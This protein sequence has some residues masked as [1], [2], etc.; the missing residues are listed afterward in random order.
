MGA[1]RGLDCEVFRNSGSYVS[2]TWAAVDAVRS[3]SY[4]I[5]SSEA[6]TNRRG[7]G[8]WQTSKQLLKDATLNVTFVK[9][10]DD[11]DFDALL[12][13]FEAGT[14]VELVAYDGGNASGSHGLDAVWE[15]QSWNETQDIDDIVLVEVTYKP[16]DDADIP[17]PVWLDDTLPTSRP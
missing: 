4:E 5:T 14:P 17:Y 15:V 3:A 10:L 12:Q 11:A 6:N 7:G 8:G 1:I 13:A 9:D 2:P 16:T